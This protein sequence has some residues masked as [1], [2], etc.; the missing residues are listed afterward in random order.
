MSRP[1][2]PRFTWAYIAEIHRHDRI[3]YIERSL[4][5][6]CATLYLIGINVLFLAREPPIPLVTVLYMIRTNVSSALNRT[7]S[8]KSPALVRGELKG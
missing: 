2:S 6:W 8:E 3:S 4:N 1:P 5:N 7:I